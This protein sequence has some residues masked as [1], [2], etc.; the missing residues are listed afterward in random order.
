MMRCLLSG[1]G[2]GINWA[3]WPWRASS[4]LAQDGFGFQ[5]QNMANT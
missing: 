3:Q 5:Q 2:T 4:D 1:G